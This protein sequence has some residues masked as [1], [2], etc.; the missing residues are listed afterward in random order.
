MGASSWAVPVG[1]LAGI[2][3]VGF[4]F[5]WFW[6]PHAW[7]RGVNSDTREVDAVRGEDREEQRRKNRETIERFTRA[8]AIERGE[9]VPEQY[10]LGHDMGAPPPVYEVRSEAQAYQSREPEARAT[11]HT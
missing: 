3:V 2:V 8:K 7:Q 5:T 9:I 10:E 6:F 11:A 4:V 1:V